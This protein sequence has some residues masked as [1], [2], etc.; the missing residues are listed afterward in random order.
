[1]PVNVKTPR[2][3]FT[4]PVRSCGNKLSQSHRVRRV[5]HVCWPTTCSM[6]LC[7]KIS[8][9]MF[10]FPILISGGST[11]VGRRASVSGCGTGARGGSQRCTAPAGRGGVRKRSLRPGFGSGWL[12]SPWGGL[13][14]PSGKPG[15]GKR[16]SAC[17]F[18]GPLDTAE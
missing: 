1:M 15:R 6:T 3:G 8:A 10:C 4:L 2:S 17:Y 13:R 9:H 5:H 12:E 7:L 14:G 11:Q 16:K 18:E